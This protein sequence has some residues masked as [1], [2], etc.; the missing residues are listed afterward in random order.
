MVPDIDGSGDAAMT[1]KRTAAALA[2]LLAFAAAPA[3]AAVYTLTYTGE[4]T[5]GADDQVF[6]VNGSLVG[7]AFTAVY[8]I[9]TGTPGATVSP[10]DDGNMVEGYDAASPVHATLTVNG[11]TRQMGDSYGSAREMDS[12]N[13]GFDYLIDYANTQVVRDGELPDGSYDYYYSY[14]Q[15]MVGFGV[16]VLKD[17]ADGDVLTPPT[18]VVLEPWDVGDLLFDET[19]YL[20]DPAADD[21]YMA[22][23]AQG[24]GKI[25]S[26]SVATVPEPAA[27]ALMILGFGG[28]GGALRR[29]RRAATA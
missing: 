23:S 19:V 26:V 20:Y 27:W 16:F 15:M 29:S 21:I 3:G 14:T 12:I 7:W 17:I 25:T 9:D 24:H 13:T 2:A 22:R 5:S 10:V 1:S 28:V 8:T 18:G 11:V 4:F 6:G